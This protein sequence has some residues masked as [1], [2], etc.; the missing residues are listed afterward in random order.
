MQN[1]FL[2][3]N[4][5]VPYLGIVVAL[6]F[7]GIS[8]ASAEDTTPI[9]AV[10]PESISTETLVTDPLVSESMVSST[11][12]VPEVTVEIAP[13]QEERAHEESVPL[14]SPAPV[15]YNLLRVIGTGPTGVP[16]P[17]ANLTMPR[18]VPPSPEQVVLGEKITVIDALIKETKRGQKSQ[19]VVDLQ[20]E[21][22]GLGFFPKRVVSSG[23]YGPVTDAA[24]KKYLSEK[25]IDIDELIAKVHGGEK[26]DAVRQ[27]QNALKS[28]G[29]FSKAIPS[30]GWY[31]PATD[32]AVK[33]YLANKK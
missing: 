15:Y 4:V 28:H 18:L 30:T 17:L 26:S 14:V 10:A 2:K 23:L 1:Y 5:L 16:K 7:L 21:L 22:K 29:E 27:L 6:C 25:I 32:A 8:F 20:N 12:S 24:V 11:E 9:E 13:I 19:K 3:K 33:K 31:G